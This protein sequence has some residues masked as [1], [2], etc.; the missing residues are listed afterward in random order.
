[1]DMNENQIYSGI[2]LQVG[3]DHMTCHIRLE[4]PPF[5]MSGPSIKQMM[6]AI[7]ERKVIFGIKEHM[8]EKL[9]EKPVYDL[10]LEI[11]KGISPVRG[12]DGEVLLHIK[13]DKDYKPEYNEEGTVDYKNI[14]HFQM[15]QKGQILGTIVPATEGQPGISILGQK[16]P[17]LRGKEAHLPLGLNTALSED[18]TQIIALCDGLI[19]YTGDRID[20]SE[21]FH[22]RANVDILTGNINFPGDV[23]IDGDV[24]SGF[25]VKSGG[26][27]IVR[28]VVEEA[29]LHAFG[30]IQI[31]RGINGIGRDAI[32]AGGDLTCKYIE[33]ASV[34]VNGNIFTDYIID[35][36]VI[37]HGNIGLSGSKEVLFGGDVRLKGELKAKEIGNLSESAT[38][39]EIL[40]IQI[41]DKDKM[42]ALMQEKNQ[43]SRTVGML[44]ESAGNIAKI[45]DK[46]HISKEIIEQ[47]KKLREQVHLLENR[48]ACIDTEIEKVGN[49]ESTIYRGTV[50]CK[51]KIY[52]GVKVCF[53][54]QKLKIEEGGM[55]FCR[56]YCHND[57]IL[58]GTL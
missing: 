19:K 41:I 40:G 38:R 22:L 36:K 54:D 32:F 5:G 26:N 10:N 6:E 9:S 42:A 20:I 44:V 17:T 45:I 25:S 48:L 49:G 2:V 58:H 14:S 53:G 8:L 16:V 29:D 24:C 15:A 39:I 28:G 7:S 21:Q 43:C 3:S 11:A 1:M 23:T 37:C 4:K 47:L 34:Q 33:S 57:E 51:R 18:K 12:T 55:D 52:P 35:S 27:I 56:I 13:K 50:S 30:G 31:A 46:G